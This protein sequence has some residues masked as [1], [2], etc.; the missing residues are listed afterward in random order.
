MSGRILELSGLS[1]GFKGQAVIHDINLRVEE[2][3]TVLAGPNGAGK[4]TLLRVMAGLIKPL[5][6][7]V[8]LGGKGMSG[9]S[10][11][12]R[13]RHIA[14]LPQSPASPWPFTVW[15]LVSQGRYSLGGFF[16]PDTGK[17]QAVERAIAQ[18]GLSGFEGRLITELSGGEYQRA[19]IAR[20]IAQ[21]SSWMLLDE[22]VSNLD[23]KHQ[24]IVMELCRSLSRAGT[25]VIISLHE[26]RLAGRYADTIIL[27]TGGRIHASGRPGAILT[28]GLVR[29]IFDLKAEEEWI[30]GIDFS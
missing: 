18:A 22:P 16:S 6:G 4:S 19:L 10:R 9:F 21:G 23:L 20:A 26:L 5:S 30:A 29:G 15:E 24:L 11:R 3:L 7:R 14:F 1:A 13:A 17:A 8:Q 25:A 12:E 28:R 2:G 27:L